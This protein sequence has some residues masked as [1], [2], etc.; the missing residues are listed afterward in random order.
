MGRSGRERHR[1]RDPGRRQLDEDGPR[2]SNR[3]FRMTDAEA[4]L[5]ATSGRESFANLRRGMPTRLPPPNR[6]FEK[7]VVPFGTIALEEV[8]SIAMVGSTSTI[9]EGFRRFIA[10][11][12]PDELMVVSHIFD[13]SAR[14]RSYELTAQIGPQLAGGS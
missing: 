3:V 1:D 12:A 2:A 10:L 8:H 9:L 14:V 6:A 4:R 11:T 13:H 7:D 5:L